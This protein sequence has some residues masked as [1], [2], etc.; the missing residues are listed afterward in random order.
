MGNGGALEA[1]SLLTHSSRF[2]RFRMAS[3]E[4]SAADWRPWFETYG[5]R[6]LLV[7]RQ[8]TRSVADAEDVVQEA[9][10]RFWRNQRHLEGDP[11]PLLVTSVRRAALDLLRSRDRR[12]KRETEHIDLHAEA[13]FKPAHEE[14]ER[15]IQLEEAVVQLPS[16]Q[17]EV[18]VLKVWGGLT[19]AQIAEQ[20]ELSPNTVASRYRYALGNLREKL[21]GVENHG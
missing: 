12:Q 8:W 5:S 7:A 16:E 3:P 4:L 9:F 18:V 21:T 11:M 19:F 6:L 20:L 2:S 14:N 10:V 15:R 17:R 13:W 1:V